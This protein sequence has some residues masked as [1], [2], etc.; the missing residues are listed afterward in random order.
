MFAARCVGIS[1][2]IFFLLY[3]S[4]SVVVS[5]AWKLLL[6]LLEQRTA[7]ASAN[8]LFVLRILPFMLAFVFTWVFTL[9]SFLLLE[10]RSTNE[11]VG[12]APTMLGACGLVLL[13]VGIAKAV[14]AQRRTS[15]ALQTWLDGSTAMDV[16]AAVPVLRTKGDAPAFTVAGLREPRVLVAEAAL[17]KLNPGEL[18]TA[19]KHEMVHVRSYDN[20][21]KLIFR[22]SVF[23]G[24]RALE[25]EWAE[26]AE[27]AADD[28]AV[29]NFGEALDLASALIKTSRL[30]PLRPSAELTTGLLHSSTALSTR[31][32][33]LFAWEQNQG[34]R[35]STGKWWY[36]LPAMA[37]LVFVMATYSSVLVRLH[38]VTEWLVR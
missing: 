38:A 35:T 30:T 19:L 14:F 28:A 13:A 22:L 10:P 11:A 20:L 4:I 27:L 6:P 21:K 23:P 36:A 5:R 1:I 25:Q 9:P 15:R 7:F 29:S 3:V 24:M 33:R 26:K 34:V 16:D 18:Q 17:A 37:T 12:V 8:L 31:V 32:E 2:A